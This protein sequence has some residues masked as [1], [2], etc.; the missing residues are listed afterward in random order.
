MTIATQNDIYKEP[1]KYNGLS[2]KLNSKFLFSENDS[3]F[4]PFEHG[5]S[6][7]PMIEPE[8]N[9]VQTS[10]DSILNTIENDKDS[11]VLRHCVMRE[12]T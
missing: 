10:R 4:A 3:D 1:S 7:D 2:K 12:K 6:A 5:L 8:R 11:R 9:E